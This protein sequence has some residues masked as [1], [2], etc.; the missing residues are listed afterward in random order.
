MAGAL[1]VAGRSVG[2]ILLSSA[3]DIREQDIVADDRWIRDGGL[4]RHEVMRFL[5]DIQYEPQWRAAADRDVDY[6]DGKQL[7]AK[8][9]ARFEARGIPPLIINLVQATINSI[10]GLEA[11]MRSDAE[12]KFD[13]EASEAVAAALNYKLK[14]AERESKADRAI[15]EAYAGQVKAGLHW[16][17][18]NDNP[19]PMQYRYRVRA[20]HRR[21]LWW[22]WRTGSG[23]PDLDDG[24]WLVR[25]K[26]Y[27]DDVIATAMPYLKNFLGG[28]RD[29]IDGLA[30]MAEHLN[31]GTTLDSS[32]EFERAITLEQAEWR[33]NDRRRSIIYEC[34]YRV[35]Q[36]SFVA[37]MPNEQVIEL[38]PDNEQHMGMVVNKVVR[39]MRALWPKMRQSFWLGPHRF[40]DRW[41]PLPHQAFPY[42]PFWGFREDLSSMPYGMV[43]AMISPQDEI[44]ARRSKMMALMSARRVRLDADALS[45]Q[46]NSHQQVANQASAHDHYIVLNPNRMNR[47]HGVDID[48]NQDLSVAQFQVLQ[49]SKSEIH[50]TS[51]VFTAQLGEGKSGQ[52]G[53]ALNTLVEQGSNTLGEI[54][55]NARFARQAVYERLLAHV[56]RDSMHP[57]EVTVGEGRAR[58]KIALNQVPANENEP[59]INPVAM[60]TARISLGEVPSS[61]TYRQHQFAQLAEMTKAMPPA[62]QQFVIDFVIES[63]DHPDRKKVA[64]RIRRMLGIPEPGAEPGAEQEQLPMGVQQEIEQGRMLVQ[65]Q[66]QMIQQLTMKLEEA[67]NSIAAQREQHGMKMEQLQA[68]RELAGA[69]HGQKMQS[70]EAGSQATQQKMDAAASGAQQPGG[71]GDDVDAEALRLLAQIAAAVEAQGKD[72]EDLKANQTKRSIVKP[73]PDGSFEVV[74]APVRGDALK[75]PA[76]STPDTAAQQAV[77]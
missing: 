9:L 28:R 5:S 2:G 6:Y 60:S 26:W 22:D 47:P 4:K 18:V 31:E 71:E 56:K 15:S 59:V 44:N 17:E 62:V 14:C 1:S 21:E 54:N 3:A 64:S 12:V 13:D 66:E 29:H 45:E 63:S 58:R 50:Q 39:P 42:V 48:S 70:I 20:V 40:L 35:W 30:A 27:D 24:R 16:V 8:V 41:T 61:A 38:D 37:R 49:E 7:D 23:D 53:L 65:Q 52:S 69:Q 75:K 72:I 34:W 36:E 43:R 76:E 55:D 68:Q 32:W 11:K 74:T 25:K 77:S 57:H 46:H 19:H 10:L 33:D 73:R 67:V 51:G